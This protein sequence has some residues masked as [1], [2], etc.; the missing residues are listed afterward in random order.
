MN[1]RQ[2]LSQGRFQR[3]LPGDV[4]GHIL[5]GGTG[6]HPK[7]LIQGGRQELDHHVTLH[8]VQTLT[9]QRHR[10]MFMES[11]VKQLLM[12]SVKNNLSLL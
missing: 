6:K 10:G 4:D 12:C 9:A 1:L 2:L 11:S 8:G 3:H 5:L 7:Q